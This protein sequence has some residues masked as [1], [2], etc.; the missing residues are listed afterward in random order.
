MRYAIIGYLALIS[1]FCSSPYCQACTIFKVTRD[2]LTLVGNNEDDNNPDTKA[3][4][5]AAEE[6]KHGR[7]FF[8]YNDS[9]PQGGMNDQRAD[10]V[11][12]LFILYFPLC[13]IH[14]SSLP[15]LGRTKISCWT[16]SYP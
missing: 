14:D 11:P 8:G 13:M 5:L 7:V 2:N 6:G 10:R 1:T 15:V 16:F 12:Y 3:W 9:I 4:F